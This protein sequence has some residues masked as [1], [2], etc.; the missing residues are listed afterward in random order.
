M[1]IYVGLSIG[2][3]NLV[4][5]SFDLLVIFVFNCSIDSSFTNYHVFVVDVAC[6]CQLIKDKY[7]KISGYGIV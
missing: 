2:F 6:A 7:I 1:I 3:Y 4:C 5:K